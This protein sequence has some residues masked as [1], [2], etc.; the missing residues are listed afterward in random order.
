MP[1]RTLIKKCIP[2]W[3]RQK[4]H[5]SK[6][7]Q[8]LQKLSPIPI[9]STSL[10]QIDPSSLAAAFREPESEK[11]WNEFQEQLKQKQLTVL[12]PGGA[13]PGD[14]RGLF[15]LVLWLRPSR[16]LEVGT[17]IGASTVHLS[18]ALRFC[19]VA[20]EPVRKLT[21]VDVVD[22]ND[23]IGQPWKH[24]GAVHSPRTLIDLLGMDKL[25]EFR[26]CPSLD[27]LKTCTDKFDLIFLDG[28]HSAKRSIRKFLP[29]FNVSTPEESFCCTTI[30]PMVSQFGQARCRFTAPFRQWNE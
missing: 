28:D 19:D 27:Y 6:E 11:R 26:V 20:D 21:T 23:P 13:N 10:K 4:I 3:V 5:Y 12:G 2:L 14:C 16:I 8:S 25:V 1:F 29:R 15:Y 7:Q 17:H 22:V 18:S 24:F 9:D 30:S